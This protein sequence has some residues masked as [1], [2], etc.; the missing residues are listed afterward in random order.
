MALLNLTSLVEVEYYP[1]DI[2]RLIDA[3]FNPGIPLNEFCRMVARCPCGMLVTR[4]SFPA[5]ECQKIVLRSVRLAQ[6]I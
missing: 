1:S 6:R 4:R 2:L 5:H 3:T